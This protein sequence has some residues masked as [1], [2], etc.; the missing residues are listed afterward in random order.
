MRWRRHGLLFTIY[1]VVGF[2]VASN[3][4]YLADVDTVAGT[5]SAILG[6]LLWPLV[7]LDFNLN[8]NF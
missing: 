7:L 1:L 4:E 8:V 3:H 2:F 5:C 6:W